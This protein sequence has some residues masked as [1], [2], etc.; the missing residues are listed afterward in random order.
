MRGEVR[1]LIIIY[2]I[3][4]KKTYLGKLKVYIRVLRYFVEHNNSKHPAQFKSIN[5]P[6]IM[7]ERIMIAAATSIICQ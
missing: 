1:E 6:A 2:C 3:E 5:Q 4:I 7:V